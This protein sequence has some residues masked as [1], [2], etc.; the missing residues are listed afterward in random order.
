[1]TDGEAQKKKAKT[2]KTSLVDLSSP[3]IAV[4]NTLYK[5]RAEKPGPLG[6]G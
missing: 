4:I 3:W 6:L 2:Q 5:V 1:V